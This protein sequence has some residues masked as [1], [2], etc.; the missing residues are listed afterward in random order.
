M[1][2]SLIRSAHTHW[3]WGQLGWNSPD[4]LLWDVARPAGGPTG[5]YV[6]QLLGAESILLLSIGLVL[7]STL[8]WV[9]RWFDGID[10]AGIWHRRVAITGMALLAP[11]SC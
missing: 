8:P 9:E 4:A 11:Q 10:R 2:S 6:G 5:G 7:I 3:S 1:P